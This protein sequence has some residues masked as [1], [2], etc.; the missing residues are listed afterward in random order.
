VLIA[1]GGPLIALSWL[2]AADVGPR[3]LSA[4]LAPH[5]TAWYALP[6]V[7][8]GFVVLGALPVM[9]LIAAT[10][11][12]FGP[13]LG[14]LY[15]MAGCLASASTA[16]AVG[17]WVGRGRLERWGGDRV[18]RITRTIRRNGTLAVFL[19][20]KIPAP[21]TLV[22]MIV[23]AS[24]VSYRDFVLG[25]TL[26]MG[27]IVVGLAGFGYHLTELWRDPSPAT[28]GR[29]GIFLLIPLTAALVINH[30]LRRRSGD[31]DPA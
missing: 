4:W 5:R 18:A 17:R 23:G 10:G 21:F 13:V 11:I 8:L 12:A 9:L 26:G 6:L 16:F 27:A 28:L 24:S 2:A 20:R 15:A 31:G 25:T 1:A 19:I 22:N 29:A 30:V 14:P 7:M 3:E